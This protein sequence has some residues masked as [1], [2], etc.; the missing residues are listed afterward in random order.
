ML[1]ILSLLNLG[2]TQLLSILNIQAINFFICLTALLLVYTQYNTAII[3][4][5]IGVAEVTAMKRR[6]FVATLL[7]TR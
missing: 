4:V 1:I 7:V 6:Y 2:F 3:R 5:S